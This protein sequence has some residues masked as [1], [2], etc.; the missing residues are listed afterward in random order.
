MHNDE[1]ASVAETKVS[2]QTTDTDIDKLVDVTQNLLDVIMSKR[3]LKEKLQSR[4]FWACLALMAVGICGMIGFNDNTTV[5]VAFVIL[6]IVSVVTYVLTE[7]YIDAAHAK[8]IIQA[9]GALGKSINSDRPAEEAKQAIEKAEQE[10][11][12]P[13]TFGTTP[14]GSQ[15]VTK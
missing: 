7:G 12:Q 1:L 4:K 15:D 13:D 14:V 3:T 5:I 11:N 9:L 8:E 2:C 10:Y 6:E